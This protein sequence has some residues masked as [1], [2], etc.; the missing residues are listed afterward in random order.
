M[1]TKETLKDGFQLFIQI[2]EVHI[3]SK[4]EIMNTSNTKSTQKQHRNGLGFHLCQE[5]LKNY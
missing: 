3:K 5:Q 4:N 1:I 2:T